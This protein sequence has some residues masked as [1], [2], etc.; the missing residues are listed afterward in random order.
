MWQTASTGAG[1]I[2]H[3]VTMNNKHPI[4]L[5][6]LLFQQ[7]VFALAL[8]GLAIEEPYQLRG[9]VTNHLTVEVS[10]LSLFHL[11]MG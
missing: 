4:H 8:N 9:G 11:N 10:L 2:N 3:N 7:R 1:L 5:Y 6:V